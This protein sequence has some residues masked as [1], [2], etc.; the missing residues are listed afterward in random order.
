MDDAFDRFRR[1]IKRAMDSEKEEDRHAA[2]KYLMNHDRFSLRDY[3]SSV[4]GYGY[5]TI[6]WLETIG[7]ATNWFDEA[8]TENV[9]ESLAFDYIS[10]S[11]LNDKKRNRIEI[12]PVPP[13]PPKDDEE[14]QWKFIEGGSDRLVLAMIEKLADFHDG[15]CPVEMN[16][17]VTAISIPEVHT[18]D[19]SADNQNVVSVTVDG[20][21]SPRRYASVINTTTLAALQKMD[22]TKLKLPYATK[23]AIR[24]LRYDP[25]TKVAIKFKKGWWMAE[26]YYIRGGLGKT[27]MPIRVCVYPS[28]NVDDHKEQSNVLL[29]S[30]SVS[31]PTLLLFQ[32][33]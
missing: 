11:D 31:P 15:K 6:H 7:S 14:V 5:E 29:C 8:F 27:D 16:K 9:L 23:A 30:Y 12:Q 2:W 20:E 4:E 13:P 17:R 21:S 19:E 33:H 25:S 32:P 10:Q 26:P 24:S 3:L 22:L 28:Y 1:K 18:M